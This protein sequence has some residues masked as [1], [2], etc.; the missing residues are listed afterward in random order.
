MKLDEGAYTLELL[1]ARR[2]YKRDADGRFASFDSLT[3]HHAA[4]G[5]DMSLTSHEDTLT[6]RSIKV[7]PDARG[8]GVATK[9]MQDLIA[10]A[11]KEGK[12]LA[13]TPD[14]L[15]KGGLSKAQLTKWYKGFGFV[16]NKGRNKDYRT[17]E[18]M[19]RKPK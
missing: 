8:K 5:A 16:P 4:E 1:L 9:A 14:P 15:G 18:T 2:K 13:L 12:T 6:L 10:Q 7:Q 17:R 3:K 11:D 19:L